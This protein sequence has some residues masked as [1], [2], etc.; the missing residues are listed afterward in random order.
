[1]NESLKTSIRHSLTGLAVAGVLLESHGL[2]S[3]GDVSSVNGAGATLADGIAAIATALIARLII[4][5]VAK[6]TGK[7]AA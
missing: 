6:A 7:G 2:I 1:M 4:F 5:L 3:A